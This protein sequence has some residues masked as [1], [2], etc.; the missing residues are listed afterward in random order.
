M[1]RMWEIKNQTATALDLSTEA[2]YRYIRGVDKDIAEFASR[3]AAHL[4]QKMD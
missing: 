2:A 4:L 1:R 3:R